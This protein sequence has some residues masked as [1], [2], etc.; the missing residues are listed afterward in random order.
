MKIYLN[1]F[2]SYDTIIHIVTDKYYEYTVVK[3]CRYTNYV[4]SATE[5]RAQLAEDNALGSE[6]ALKTA[7]ERIATLEKRLEDLGIYVADDSE[8]NEN[9]NDNASAEPRRP[10][11]NSVVKS[12]DDGKKKGKTK[13]KKK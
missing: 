7:Q 3:P 8:A 6:N 9:K 11:A 4:F 10:S 12:A 1:L 2:S 5:E 13:P